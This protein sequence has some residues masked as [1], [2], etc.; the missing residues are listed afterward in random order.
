MSKAAQNNGS[1]LHCV[2]TVLIVNVFVVT[3]TNGKPVDRQLSV[4]NAICEQIIQ[5]CSY[6][7]LHT[8]DEKLDLRIAG[9]FPEH[10]SIRMDRRQ[11]S[12]R[13]PILFP[14]VQPKLNGDVQHDDNR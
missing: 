12:S 8:R 9:S 14:V 11:T 2:G 6:F 1:Q 3:S 7:F 5:F 4:I 13:T 10:V